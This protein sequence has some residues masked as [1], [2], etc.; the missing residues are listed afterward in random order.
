[1]P[2]TEIPKYTFPTK[3]PRPKSRKDQAPKR[4]RDLWIYVL[5]VTSVFAVYGQV[6]HF[7]FVNYDDPDYITDNAHVRAGLT[8]EGAAWAFGSSFAGNWFPLTWLSHMMDCEIFGLR[9]GWHHLTNVWIHALSTLLLF[10]LLR[11]MTG[12]RWPSAVVAFL[13]ALH[14][15]HVQSV[16]WIAER[17]DVLSALFWMLTLW[18]YAGYVARPGAG[19]YA[20][21][22]STF[23]LGLM[24]KPMLVTLPVVLFLLDYWPLRRDARLWSRIREKLPLIA[25]SIAA[26]VVTYLVQHRAK[27]TASLEL[28]PVATRFENALVSYVVYIAKMFWPTG[29]AVFYPYSRG[30][31]AGPAALAGIALAAVTVLVVRA[32]TRRP[33]LAVGWLWYLCTLVPVIGLVQVG[34]QARADRYMYIPMIGLAIAL[35]WS[36]EELLRSRPR[37]RI[38]LT[39]AAGAACA[40]VTWTQVGYWQ[41][42]YSLFQH[43]V[44]VT[45]DNWVARFN[46]ASLLDVRGQDQE[47]I[48]QLRE[49]VR[50]KPNFAVAHAELGQILARQG[51]TEEGILELQAAVRLKPDDADAH[52]RLGSALGTV[53]RTD[54]A[55]AEFSETVRLQPDNADAHYNLGI[56]LAG[57]EKLQEAAGE[58]G[59]AVRLRPDDAYASFNWGITLARLGRIDEAIAAFSKAI[60]LKPDFAEARQALQDALNLKRGPGGRQP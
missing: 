45:T 9:A 49:V 19:R 4:Q 34:A 48:T 29:L 16:A 15:L 59:A 25:I 22:A 21:L 27:A 23:C 12:S 51:Q 33:Y 24:A 17:K 46:L 3:M 28:V 31:L 41:D 53:G 60:Q 43:A 35:A 57:Q 39:A 2:V 55:A 36:A 47:A 30:S 50:L 32:F 14:P 18:A 37:T 7:D 10:A 54:Q 58:F 13:F 1:M 11:R 38:A 52:Y 8:A 42:G 44:A 40:V 5:L 6:L 56:A 26:S 20:L